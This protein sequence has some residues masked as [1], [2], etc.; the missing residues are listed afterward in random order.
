MK[1]IFAVRR[2]V[3]TLAA[4]AST[5]VV[6]QSKPQLGFFITSANPGKGADLGGLAGADKHCQTLAAAAGAGSAHVARVSQ[7]LGGQ[8]Q[9]GRQR[10][11]SHRHRPVVQ[12]QGRAGRRRTSPISTAT[13]TSWQGKLAHREGRGRQRPR[14]HAEHARHHDRLAARRHGASGRQSRPAATGR[15]A[16]TARR[17]SAITTARAAARTRRRGTP[18]TRSKGCSQE[19]LQGT[20][21]DGCFYCF[22]AK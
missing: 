18:R 8:R 16:R 5:L 9:A 7:H 6:A 1:R 12:R 3:I 2:C 21:G 10:Q 11:G 13:T 19:V 20:G 15:A 22:A 17:R 14:R 4:L